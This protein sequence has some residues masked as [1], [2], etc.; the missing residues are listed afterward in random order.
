V[1]LM[2]YALMSLAQFQDG[3]SVITA[4][5]VIDITSF[6]STNACMTLIASLVC[7]LVI[8]FPVSLDILQ[9]LHLQRT[10]AYSLSF[11][12]IP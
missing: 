11:V 4:G 5:V 1:G 9:L 3:L 10:E 2:L 6:P 7:S 12:R 8:S